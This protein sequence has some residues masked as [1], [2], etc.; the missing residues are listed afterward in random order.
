[1]TDWGAEAHKAAQERLNALSEVQSALCE[2]EEP[3]EDLANQL[4]GPC[5]EGCDTCTI[6]EVLDAAWPVFLA[7]VR[8]GDYD[9]EL[10]A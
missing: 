8:S 5:C 7:G 4:S 9:E 2:G 10:A 3:D 6:R 1:M